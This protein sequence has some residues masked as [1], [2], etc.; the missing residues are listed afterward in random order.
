MREAKKAKVLEAAQASFLR[1]GYRR[2]TM[3]D[4]ASAAGLSRPALYLH[5]CNKENI[6]EAVL[7]AFMARAIEEV[8]AGLQGHS[9]VEDQLRFAFEVWAVRPFGL[10]TATPDAKELIDCRFE[11][12]REAIDQGAQAFEAELAT[13]LA[14]LLAQTAS[15]GTGPQDVARILTRAVQGF[16]QTATSPED[17][18]ALIHGLLNLVLP[19]LAAGRAQGA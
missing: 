5:F 10:L 13:I 16:K 14:P 1:Y 4:I 2:V 11:F 8:R 15:S 12:A 3:G 18:R 6:F 17:L 7:R 19:S 9:S